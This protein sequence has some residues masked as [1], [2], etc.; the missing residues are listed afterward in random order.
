MYLSEWIYRPNATKYREMIAVST[1]IN[2][3]WKK[4]GATDTYLCSF[5]GSDMGCMASTIA[6]E[7]A[8]AFGKSSDAISANPEAGKNRQNSRVLVANGF[9]ITC[10]EASAD[11][12]IH[13][14]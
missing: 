12:M 14:Q 2:Q 10:I 13:A 7:N 6:F 9:G 5:N 11:D 8:E 1:S 3:L 4:H